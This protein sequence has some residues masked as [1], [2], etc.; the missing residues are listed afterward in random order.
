MN[1]EQ[2]GEVT[3]PIA[4]GKAAQT[5]A[6]E[7]ETGFDRLVLDRLLYWYRMALRMGNVINQAATGLTVDGGEL[8]ELAAIYRKEAGA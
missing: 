1:N 8:D 6:W 5:E 2:Q 4:S 3:H 7:A